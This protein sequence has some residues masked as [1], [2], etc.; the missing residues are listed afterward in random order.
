MEPSK[1]QKEIFSLSSLACHF[2]L[3]SPP[4]FRVS[5]ESIK[6]EPADDKCCAVCILSCGGG[7]GGNAH[8][9][10][11]PRPRQPS[12]HPAP[13]GFLMVSTWRSRSSFLGQLIASWPGVF[14]SFEPMAKHG[15]FLFPFLFRCHFPDDYIR[16]SI[17]GTNHVKLNR[18]RRRRRIWNECKYHERPSLCHQPP[19][20]A[21][22]CSSFPANFDQSRRIVGQKSRHLHHQFVV[23]SCRPSRDG[24]LENRRPAGPR[25][26][27]ATMASRAKLKWCMANRNSKE[28][29]LQLLHFSQWRNTS[30]DLFASL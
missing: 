1:W 3:A 15:P 19:M 8:V 13:G 25:S 24:P 12:Q 20:L 4:G 26:L 28:P 29:V 27:A 22:L 11:Q 17:N 23:G 6:D 2:P 5:T 10:A 21:Q 30:K 14:Y 9:D 16:G 18:R 7:G